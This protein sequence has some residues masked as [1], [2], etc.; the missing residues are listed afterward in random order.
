MQQTKE[1]I[2]K[3]ST[4]PMSIIIVGIGDENFDNMKI[5]DGDKGLSTENGMQCARDIV[6]FVPFNKYEGNSDALAK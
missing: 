2:I 5:L 4:L 3:N 6:Q 1:V